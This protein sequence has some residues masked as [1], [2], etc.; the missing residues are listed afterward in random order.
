MCRNS[1]LGGFPPTEEPVPSGASTPPTGKVGVTDG[2]TAEESGGGGGGDG[3]F[4]GR[5]G[6]EFKRRRL[7][8]RVEATAGGGG[9]GGSSGE[10]G[11]VDTRPLRCLASWSPSEYI[12]RLDR[13]GGRIND[14]AWITSGEGV[15]ELV[16]CCDFFMCNDAGGP[17]AVL[18]EFDRKECPSLCPSWHESMIRPVCSIALRQE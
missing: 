13:L 1:L 12:S 18:G 15:V 9:G 7:S 6:L 4:H 8:A 2:G 16:D 14:L 17:R 11:C 5:T 10:R 3:D